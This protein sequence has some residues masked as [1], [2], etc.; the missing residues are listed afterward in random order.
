MGICRNWNNNIM[1]KEDFNRALGRIEGKL[2]ELDKHF[3]RMNRIDEDLEELNKRIASVEKKQYGILAVATV[4]WTAI[5][6]LI[7]SVF[8]NK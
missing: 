2:N 6:V 3:D 5:I 7:K 8:Y 1:E 4:V